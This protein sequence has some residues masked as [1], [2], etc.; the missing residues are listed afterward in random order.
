M[1]EHF[2][3]Q[4]DREEPALSQQDVVAVKKLDQATS[5]RTH[6]LT[7]DV[8]GNPVE[9]T[10]RLQLPKSYSAFGTLTSRAS[11]EAAAKL[12]PDTTV[13]PSNF[14][15]L[16]ARNSA[17][18]IY[19][20][21][22]KNIVSILRDKEYGSNVDDDFEIDITIS[23]YNFGTSFSDLTVRNIEGKCLTEP[24]NESGLISLKN[25]PE[26]TRYNKTTNLPLDFGSCT[27]RT[28]GN[29]KRFV[30]ISSLG[31]YDLDLTCWTNVE[32]GVCHASTNYYGWKI[33]Y[34]F[35]A[36]H[37]NEHLSIKSGVFAFLEE[38]TV[39]FDKYV[40]QKN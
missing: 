14:I 34:R 40:Q 8:P 27:V 2:N 11:K 24:E 33:R 26:L 39:E 19:Q 7:M 32:P 9:L 18:F 3:N 30:H 5:A 1:Y 31:E 20:I 16:K 6:V 36:K 13:Y 4:V 10:W 38:H 28:D 22:W 25:I 29:S 23:T 15:V 21:K 35:P 17:L 37:M 12:P